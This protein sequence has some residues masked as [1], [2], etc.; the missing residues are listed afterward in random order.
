[1]KCNYKNKIIQTVFENV[2][3]T[4]LGQDNGVDCFVVGQIYSDHIGK[5]DGLILSAKYVGLTLISHLYKPTPQEVNEFQY[6]NPKFALAKDNDILFF[7]SKFGKDAWNSTAT[8][9]SLNPEYCYGLSSQS[10]LLCMLLFDT[11]SGKLVAN[12][13]LGLHFDF[14]KELIEGIKEQ[15]QKYCP[16]NTFSQKVRA[17]YQKYPNDN[18][19]LNVAY[20]QYDFV[21]NKIT[22]GN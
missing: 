21:K 13:T 10:N 5:P 1:M 17:T 6:G 20:C 8:N 15:A 12:R 2:S 11:S 14:T 7:L 16:I 9:Y 18:E 4:Y 22:G 3:N 19:L